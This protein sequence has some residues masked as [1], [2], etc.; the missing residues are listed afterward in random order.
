[1][2]GPV[3]SSNECCIFNEKVLLAS[4]RVL[5]KAIR[6]TKNKLTILLDFKENKM[7]LTVNIPIKPAMS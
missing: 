7:I 6:N 4:I 2:Y 5:A 3:K 1:L